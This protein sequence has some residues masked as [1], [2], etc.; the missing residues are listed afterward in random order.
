MYNR[1]EK[2]YPKKI[3]LNQIRQQNVLGGSECGGAVGNVK[4]TT[5]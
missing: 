1:N 3:I 5:F 4:Q 2:K